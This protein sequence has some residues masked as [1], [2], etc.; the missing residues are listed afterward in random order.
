MPGPIQAQRAN[1]R[2]HQVARAADNAAEEKVAS[3][4]AH[5][6]RIGIEC[7]VAVDVQRGERTLGFPRLRGAHVH[8]GVDMVRA[9]GINGVDSVGDEDSIAA[10]EVVAA[11]KENRV[12]GAVGA[13]VV[14]RE[15]LGHAGLEHQVIA[16]RGRDVADPIASGGK[17]A[18][19]IAGPK[20]RCSA[21]RWK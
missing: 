21:R 12:K 14:R 8:V 9:D 20:P 1:V 10:H 19:D 17:V 15:Q 2:L 11:L 6:Q 13:E 5:R 7:D 3:V 16:R 4:R 18:I